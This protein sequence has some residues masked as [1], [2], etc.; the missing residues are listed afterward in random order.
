VVVRLVIL[1]QRAV[2]F[3]GTDETYHE[4]V[5]RLSIWLPAVVWTALVL[6]FSSG[7]FREE[8][9]GSLL[10]PLLAWLLPWLTL[11]QIGAIHG[12][13]RRTAHVTE[14]AILALLLFR[15][16]VRGTRLGAQGSAWLALAISVIAAIVDESHRATL[17]DRTGSVRDVLLDSFGAAAALVPAWLGWCRVAGDTTSVILWIAVVGGVSALVF[18]LAA[19]TTSGAVLWL[20]VPVAGAVLF[21]CWRGTASSS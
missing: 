19:G 15:S 10:R 16:L 18:G 17:P 6:W 3:P 21:L 12:L 14:Y 4:P 1:T 2:R 7:D 13:I 9:T 20:T 11:K 5:S 8:N